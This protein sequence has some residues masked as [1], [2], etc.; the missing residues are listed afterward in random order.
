AHWLTVDTLRF[1]HPTRETENDPRADLRSCPSRPHGIADAE[2]GRE[3]EILRRRHGHDGQWPEGLFGLF[4][5]LG[6][7]RAIFAEA[8]GFE[9]LRHGAHGAARPQPA[10]AGA[11]RCRAEGLRLRHRLG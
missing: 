4:A 10:G 8:D 3:P 6:R 2:A 1:A 11:P 7:L 9:N 5:R